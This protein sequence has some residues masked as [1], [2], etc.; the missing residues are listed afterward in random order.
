MAEVLTRDLNEF[1]HYWNTHIIRGNP[2][3]GFKAARPNDLYELPGSYG[4]MIT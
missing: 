1:V 3:I 2:I 4:K